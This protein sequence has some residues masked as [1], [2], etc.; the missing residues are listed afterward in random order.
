[1]IHRDGGLEEALDV[2]DQIKED[3]IDFEKGI[4][5]AIGYKEFYEFY[6]W[7]KSQETHTVEDLKS[8]LATAKVKLC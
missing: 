5:Q 1:M 7:H 3:E 6:Q 4:L 8:K 2:F